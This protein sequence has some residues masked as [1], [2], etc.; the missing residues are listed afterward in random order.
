MQTLK[1]I[2][3]ST[4]GRSISPTTQID[5]LASQ[6][7][8]NRFASIIQTSAKSRCVS[9]SDD[10]QPVHLL[11][12]KRIRHTIWT[13]PHILFESKPSCVNQ[14]LILSQFFHKWR[15][16]V[17]FSKEFIFGIIERIKIQISTF[18]HLS[19]KKRIWCYFDV[20]HRITCDLIFWF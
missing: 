4:L 17:K 6:D 14:W 18:C 12:F 15:N 13:G 2:A 16:M 11:W 3:E 10:H 7:C 8:I 20:W 1:T 5:Q 19:S 9:Y